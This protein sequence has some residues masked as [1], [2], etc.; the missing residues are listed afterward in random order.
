MGLLDKLLEEGSKVLKEVASDENKEKA[1]K[2]ISDLATSAE[3]IISDLKSEETK[4]KAA[5]FLAD[6]EDRFSGLNNEKTDSEEPEYKEEYYEQDESDERSCREKIL[7][8][9]ADEFP[10]YEVREHVSPHTIGGEG[11]FMDY[12]IV[13]YDGEEPKLFIMIIGKTTTS[14]R[15]YRWSREQAESQGY[16][17]IN[18]IEHYP[19][20]V[21]Y[22]SERLHGYLK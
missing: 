22:I 5:D 12:D 17:F 9:L 1:E 13:V 6:L 21:E 19:N 4:D 2:F 3:G 14:H 10:Q 8:V 7:V 15:E 20:R 18:F 11:R 16:K